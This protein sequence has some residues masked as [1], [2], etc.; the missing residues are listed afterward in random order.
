M[1][2]ARAMQTIS[3]AEEGQSVSTSYEEGAEVELSDEDFARL[4]EAGAVIAAEDY[5]E[6]EPEPEEGADEAET[7]GEEPAEGSERLAKL[8]HRELDDLGEAHGIEFDEKASKQEKA[9]A[10]AEAG[11]E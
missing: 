6:P 2:L 7:A 5:E 1:P 9:D 4:S 10:L 3:V 11:V 8:T